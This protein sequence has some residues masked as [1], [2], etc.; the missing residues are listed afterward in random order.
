MT[1]TVIVK[2]DSKLKANAQKTAADLGLTL[3]AVI[4]GYL[5]D[6]VQKK[7]ASFGGNEKKYKDPYGIF[8]ASKITDKDIEEVTSSW[9]KIIDELA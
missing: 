6:F 7:S 3:S 2:T 8:K 4:N 5:K 9:D 1:S